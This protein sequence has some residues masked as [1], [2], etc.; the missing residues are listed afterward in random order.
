MFSARSILLI[1]SAFL[2]ASCSAKSLI[3]TVGQQ[4]TALFAPIQER[5]HHPA[6]GDFVAN[7]DTL[8]NL[9]LLVEDVDIPYGDKLTF[10]M[11]E[12]PDWLELS[13]DGLLKGTPKNSDVG[14]DEIIVRVTDRS[15]QSD[16][17]VFMITVV[18]TNDAPKFVT[19]SLPT[20]IQDSA[21]EMAIEVMDDD[22]PYGD[23]MRF[24]LADG[25]DW[26]QIS[27][28]GMLGGTPANADVGDYIVVI[29]L[30]DKAGTTIQQEFKLKV[31]NINDA[32][33]FITSNRK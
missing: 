21:Y 9:Q 12:L 11:V 27:K 32:P 5:V 18:N 19:T 8:Y 10:S 25:P 29:V 1:C 26:L 16:D 33:V 23:V 4:A 13:R 20:A 7:E 24:K 14:S 22:I 15:G 2:L 6:G 30:S 3:H 31:E 17:A 28:D